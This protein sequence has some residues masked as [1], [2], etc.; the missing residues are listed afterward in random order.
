M[1]V[2]EIKGQPK[3]TT[4]CSTAAADGME[5]RTDTPAVAE[6]R[7]GVVE[8]L[9]LNHPLDCPLCDKAG[10]CKLQDYAY[11]YGSGGGRSLEPKNRYGYED[12][13]AKIVIDKN[14]CIHCTRCVRF[15][16]DI[17]GAGELTATNRG[18]HL[19]ITTF[20]GLTLDSNPFA[21]N[22]VDNCPVGALTSRDFRFK[23]RSWYLKP[24]PTISRHGADAKAIW[25]DVAQNKLWRFR[26]RPDGD[27]SSTQFI[28]DEERNA[29]QRYCI[30]PSQRQTSPT[31]HKKSAEAPDIAEALMKSTP[32]AVVAQGT[33]GCNALQQ[34]GGL[35]TFESLRYAH[36]NKRCPIQNAAIQKSE[37]GVI[38]RAGITARG[39]R[40]DALNELLSKIEAGEVKSAVVYHDSEFSDDAENTLIRRIVEKVPF[41]LLLEPI[42]SDLVEVATATLPVT[43]YLEE[44]DFIIGYDGGEKHYAQA[45]EPPKGI[46]TPATWTKELSE[47]TAAVG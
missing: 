25:A 40:F 13:G 35:A 17:T 34:L 9:A 32:V 19:E 18:S 7:A 8:F 44:S 11:L 27:N 4:S 43:T 12:L 20:A 39:F 33:F 14:R 22:L 29:W 28:S 2:V 24:V 38:N 10:E 21:G 23:K 30:D 26:P 36:G 45:L 3:L 31:L 42:P 47:V 1:C 46:K 6:A 41:S 16:R 5:V 37:D 15:T